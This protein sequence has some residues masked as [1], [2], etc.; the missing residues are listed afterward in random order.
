MAPACRL[1]SAVEPA[2]VMEDLLLADMAATVQVGGVASSIDG[3]IAEWVAISAE[4]K[5]QNDQTSAKR[6]DDVAV[7][8][9]YFKRG[10]CDSLA[11]VLP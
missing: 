6:C 10:G 5:R 8:L 1:P 3:W 4:Y 9:R 7:M 11:A 2:W